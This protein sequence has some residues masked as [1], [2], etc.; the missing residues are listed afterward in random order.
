[1]RQQLPDCFLKIDSA[2]TPAGLKRRS[3]VK[4]MSQFNWLVNGWFFV[5]GREM[6]EARIRAKPIAN[7]T[8]DVLD[9][10]CHASHS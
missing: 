1:M 9:S 7:A 8:G 5:P 3:P 2:G 6:L 10:Q 4:N